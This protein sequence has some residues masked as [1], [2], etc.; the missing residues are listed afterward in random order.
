[1]CP[2]PDFS[3][4]ARVRDQ[5]DATTHEASP[6]NN[7]A[8]RFTLVMKG[9]PDRAEDARVDLPIMI[10]HELLIKM[11]DSKLVLILSTNG[12]GYFVFEQYPKFYGLFRDESYEIQSN[13][14]N[15]P[16]WSKVKRKSFRLYYDGELIVVWSC[17]GFKKSLC[18][19]RGG[20]LLGV[21]SDPLDLTNSKF[22]MNRP[23][24]PKG[25][26]EDE[27]E[28]VV[29]LGLEMSFISEY[30]LFK[31]ERSLQMIFPRT[32]IKLHVNE[33]EASAQL[34]KLSVRRDGDAVPRECSFVVSNGEFRTD[35]GKYFSLHGLESGSA[36]LIMGRQLMSLYGSIMF[37]RDGRFFL[38]SMPD[39]IRER[40]IG[41]DVEVTTLDMGLYANDEIVFQSHE[42]TAYPSYFRVQS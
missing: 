35:S 7:F 30:A 23:L 22:Y 24:N 11:A 21:E 42:T 4:V 10:P 8:L 16:G 14:P 19:V 31:E 12:I 13:D 33:L 29:N 28:A 36:D 37:L 1:M 6:I 39:G 15:N 5:G 27:H 17:A 38:V 40:V 26:L 3:Q 20:V 25:R 9:P 41:L 34:V 2:V 18:K 32:G